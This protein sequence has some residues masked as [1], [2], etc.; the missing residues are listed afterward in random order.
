MGVIYEL[1]LPYRQLSYMVWTYQGVPYMIRAYL[2]MTL[3]LR[4]VLYMADGNANI[5][6]PLLV[7][8]NVTN[9]DYIE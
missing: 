8:Y 6:F 1:D 9:V 2:W 7:Y 5:S 3:L 4:T